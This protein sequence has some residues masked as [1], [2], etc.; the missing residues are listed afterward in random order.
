MSPIKPA[1]PGDALHRI[2]RNP[3][4]Q[5]VLLDYFGKLGHVALHEP[6]VEVLQVPPGVLRVQGLESL[7]EGRTFWHP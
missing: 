5:P 6:F 2:D 3:M 1:F 4:V 7:H